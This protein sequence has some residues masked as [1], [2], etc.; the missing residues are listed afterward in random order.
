MLYLWRRVICV[1]EISLKI[2]PLMSQ[3]GKVRCINVAS[4]P[5]REAAV[6]VMLPDASQLAC[7]QV[8]SGHEVERGGLRDSPAAG[9]PAPEAC[10]GHPGQPA[11]QAYQEEGRHQGPPGVRECG[12]MGT[13]AASAAH[14]C[15]P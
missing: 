1:S 12:L 3:Q 13:A 7:C 14:Q 15:S 4:G 6:A 5:I 10:A 9:L 11:V 8:S 2:A